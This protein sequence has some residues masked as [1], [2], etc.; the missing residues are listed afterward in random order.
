[1]T[2]TISCAEIDALDA[3]YALGALEPHDERR[4]S[5]H[6]ATCPEPH[7]ELRELV[8][9]AGALPESVVPLAPDPLLRDRLMSAVAPD[10]RREA[11]LSPRAPSVTVAT[12]RRL[13][14]G[15]W[16]SPR[17][18]GVL[19]A[20]VVVALVGLTGWNMQLRAALDARSDALAQAAAALADSAAAYRVEGSAGS[21]YLVADDAGAASLVVTDLATLPAEQVYAMWLHSDIGVASAGAFAPPPE[22]Q[23]VVADLERPIEDYGR[24]TVTVESGRLEAPTTA[25]VMAADIATAAGAVGDSVAARSEPEAIVVGAVRAGRRWEG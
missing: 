5:E 21:G 20:A 9:V 18:A 8:A 23:I 6:L 24:F 2:S 13:R 14:L 16:L 12:P 11:A 25:P 1:M 3:A 19:T 17:L 10:S 4:I 15:G 22:Q 7:A